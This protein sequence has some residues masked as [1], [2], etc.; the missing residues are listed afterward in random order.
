[1]A[2]CDGDDRVEAIIACS[3]VTGEL[4]AKGV[5]RAGFAGGWLG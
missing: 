4:G 3:V 5:N 2:D 1:M